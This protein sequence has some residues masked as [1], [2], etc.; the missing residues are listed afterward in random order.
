MSP[1]SK[2]VVLVFLLTL[3]AVY[4]AAAVILLAC[5]WRKAR[6]RP[7]PQ[8][9]APARWTRRGVL[10][11]AGGGMGCMAWGYFVEPYRIE[12]THTRISSGKLAG[13]TRPVRLVQIS[14]LHCDL[15]VR[16]EEKLPG[17]VADLRPDLIV[18][19]G[20]SVNTPAALGNFHKC[21]RRIARI[22][23]TYACK[24]NWDTYFGPIDYFGPTGATEL[25]GTARLVQVA[26]G[27]LWVAGAAVGRRYGDDPAL[28]RRLD[29][30]LAGVGD[31]DFCVFLYH[32]PG[33]IYELAGRGVDLCCAGHTHGG[34]VALP[35]YGALITLARYG[36]RFEA[37]LY[38]VDDAYLYV[39]RGI[40]MEGGRAPRLRFWC[41]PEVGLIE[42]AHEAPA[43]PEGRKPGA[44]KTIDP[45]C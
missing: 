10:G 30:A 45:R 8:R 37:G 17:I 40:G 26:G 33:L 25:D 28:N 11:L 4:A 14:D 27:R 31:E 3:G 13:L 44:A 36:K 16:N 2:I 34:Q 5:L 7:Q 18:Y 22:A 12:V 41:R 39:N 42:L 38:R 29:R 35:L 19:T 9:S 32:Y 20:D 15:K 21:L 24:G 23:P 6:R 43:T 1:V